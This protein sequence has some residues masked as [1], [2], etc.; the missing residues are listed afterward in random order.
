MIMLNCEIHRKTQSLASRQHPFVNRP[1][2]IINPADCIL[3]S[4]QHFSLQ[5]Y[6]RPHSSSL[7]DSGVCFVYHI[8]DRKEKQK[9]IKT[10]KC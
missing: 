5:K 6:P 9:P 7:L 4:G 1:D 8:L 3:W 2:Y 10:G